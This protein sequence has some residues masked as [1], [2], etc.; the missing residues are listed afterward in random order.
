METWLIQQPTPVLPSYFKD[1][2][3]PKVVHD[4]ETIKKSK[5]ADDSELNAHDGFFL[6]YFFSS[7]GTREVVFIGLL[8]ALSLGSTLGVVPAV[9]E[10]RYARLHYGFDGDLC[11]TYGVEDK[12]VKCIHGSEDAQNASAI[13]TFFS[14]FLSFFTSSLI[15][16]I[17]DS[18]GRR[19]VLLIGVAISLLSPVALVWMQMDTTSH[20]FWFYVGHSISGIVN[21]MSILFSSLSD[22]VPPRLRAPSFALMMAGFG[23]GFAFSPSLALLFGH[24]GVS[25]FSLLLQI[26]CFLFIIFFY[27]ETLPKEVSTASLLMKQKEALQHKSLGARCSHMI[28]RPFRELSIINR[29]N[30][31]RFLSSLAFLSGVTTSADQSLL[32][33]YIEDRIGFGDKDVALLFIVF[34]FGSVFVQVFVLKPLNDFLG[35][36]LV[37]IIAFLSGSCVN[38]LYGF[39][40]TKNGIFIGAFLNAFLGMSFPTIS[41]IKSNN[42]EIHEQGRI[43]GALYSLSSLASA[44][45]PI[46]LRYIY[47]LTKDFPYPGPGT[48][49]LFASLLYFI[50][51]IIAFDLPKE[52]SDSKLMEENANMFNNRSE[53]D[54]DKTSYGSIGSNNS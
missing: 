33:Y 31:F 30:V 39:A 42:V 21:W 5:S 25:I 52:K 48:M 4:V 24:L 7:K 16:S 1:S 28:L 47:H 32:L 13:D 53:D 12:P 35:E 54:T 49:F 26:G 6:R 15:G 50:A 38:A 51:V 46:S 43:Q 36:R 41:A 20:P 17:S 3:V 37:L 11:Y 40:R 22:V 10:D 9:T 45:G 2:P 34:G 19:P 29:N 14:D 8:F 44:I 27:P 23:L 18:R